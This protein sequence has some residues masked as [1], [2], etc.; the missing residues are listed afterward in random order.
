MWDPN[1]TGP[2]TG[3]HYQLAETLCSPPP[4]TRPPVM[5]GGSGERKTLRLV[6]RYGDACN[7]FASSPSDVAHKLDVLAR[8]CDDTG[9]DSATVTRTILHVGGTLGSGNVDGF[10]AEM[11]DYARLG[12]EQVIVMPTGDQPDRWIDEVCG[13]VAP[14]LA[15]L[16]AGA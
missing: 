7:L 14:R 8:H 13:E 11:S 2:Y 9:R 6:A 1:S 16:G 4:I 5:I 3:R 10:L 15:E 12:I